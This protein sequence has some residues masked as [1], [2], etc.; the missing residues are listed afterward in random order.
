MGRRQDKESDI[1][2]KYINS[3]FLCKDSPGTL[4]LDRNNLQNIV[5]LI[6]YGRISPTA[7]ML[8]TRRNVPQCDHA[9]KNPNL[10]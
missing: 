1:S 9:R 7:T 2:G 6:F 10:L 5:L 8:S 4:L 3:Y